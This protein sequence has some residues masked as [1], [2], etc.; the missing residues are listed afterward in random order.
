[1]KNAIFNP[2]NFVFNLKVASKPF[3][4][5]SP[6]TSFGFKNHEK[7]FLAFLE[8]NFIFVTQNFIKCYFQA[9]RIFVFD[10]MEASKTVFKNAFYDQLCI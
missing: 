4:K 9:F 7:L 3:S 5:M 6:M 2:Q 10:L 8:K 1:M